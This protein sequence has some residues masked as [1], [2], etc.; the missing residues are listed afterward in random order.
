QLPGHAVRR[1]VRPVR[2]DPGFRLDE[3]PGTGMSPGPGADDPFAV[4]AGVHV[5]G[6]E[7]LEPFLDRTVDEGQALTVGQAQS[8]PGRTRDAADVAGAEQEAAGLL[9]ALLLCRCDPGHMLP[10]QFIS[11]ARRWTPAC[12]LPRRRAQAARRVRCGG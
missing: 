1:E 6:V 4:P 3:D 12:H 10:L 7:Y 2:G 11:R 8:R 5:G 9:A